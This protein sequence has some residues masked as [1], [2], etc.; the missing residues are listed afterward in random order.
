M[1]FPDKRLAS[2]GNLIKRIYRFPFDFIEKIGLKS[3]HLI[4]VNSQFTKKVVKEEFNIQ[5]V[6]ILYPCVNPNTKVDR[7]QPKNPIYL[8]INRFERKKN[9]SL[10]IEAF[11]LFSQ[12]HPDS[13]LIVAGGYDPKVIENVEHFKELEKLV[14]KLNLQS[15]V[16]FQRDLNDNDKWKLIATST[17]V[18]YTP[19]N[20][21]FGIV[22][23][24]ALSLGTPVI[25]CNS[26]GP[27][28]TI[29]DDNYLCEPNAESFCNAMKRAFFNPE[30]P[31]DLRKKCEKF[32]FKSFQQEW[33]SYVQSLL[34]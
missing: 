12:E 24:E 27:I 9:H 23:I 29:A 2:H 8:S 21:H 33:I 19:Q 10:A 5:N 20:E 34:N 7:Q 18:L 30:N 4:L 22:P 26:G 15:K 6:Q 11:N 31:N 25:G 13:E 32:Y 16:K 28:E 14:E 1:H 17:A 3:S